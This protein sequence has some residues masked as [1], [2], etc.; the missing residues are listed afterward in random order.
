MASKPLEGKVSGGSDAITD[1]LDE[2]EKVPLKANEGLGSRKEF[3][4]AN[5]AGS[6]AFGHERMIAIGTSAAARLSF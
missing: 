1:L 6:A 4:A 5:T 2:H 3:P